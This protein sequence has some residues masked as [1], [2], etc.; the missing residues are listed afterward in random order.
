[1]DL[2][3]YLG[4][5]DVACADRCMLH[6]QLIKLEFERDVLGAVGAVVVG[7]AAAGHLHVLAHVDAPR[8]VRVAREEAVVADFDAISPGSR[9]LS[10]CRLS[11]EKRVSN[12]HDYELSVWEGVFPYQM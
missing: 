8:V 12:V 7:E 1:M 4:G 9:Q 11:T 10:V 2:Q 5:C 3:T 6:L